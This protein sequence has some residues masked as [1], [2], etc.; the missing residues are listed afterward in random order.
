MRRRRQVTQIVLG[1]FLALLLLAPVYES[2]DRWD[3]FP[4][5]GND[6][7][8]NLIGTVTLCGLVLVTAQNLPSLLS[9][10]VSAF[11]AVG[12]LFQVRCSSLSLGTHS[13]IGESPPPL[14]LSSLRI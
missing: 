10:L 12:R 13:S 14:F 3:G 7:M 9:A 2:F 11:P 6:T 4:R 5:S 8:L 1:C